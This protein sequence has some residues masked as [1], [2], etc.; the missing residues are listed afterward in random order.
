[1]WEKIKIWIRFF[2]GGKMRK[3]F[4]TLEFLLKKMKIWMI[5]VKN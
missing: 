1:M 4:I 2:R 3:E 5:L